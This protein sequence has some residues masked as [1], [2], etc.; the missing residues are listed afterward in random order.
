VRVHRSYLVRLDLIRSVELYAKNS[1]EAVLKD[2]TRIP[3]SREGH[4]RLREL[5]GDAE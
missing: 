2:G 3:V 4:E 1:R 5:L